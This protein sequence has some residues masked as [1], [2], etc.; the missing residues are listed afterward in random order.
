VTVSDEMKPGTKH[1]ED[2]KMVERASWQE[3]AVEDAIRLRCRNAPEFVRRSIDA[4]REARGL[5]PLWPNVS[6]RAH[7]RTR[8]TAAV[9]RL[10]AFLVSATAGAKKGA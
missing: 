8:A 7:A 4:R 3:A 9:S 5:R 1:Q 6:R 10:R 2:E